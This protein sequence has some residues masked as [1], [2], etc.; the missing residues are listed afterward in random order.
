MTRT[1]RIAPGPALALLALVLGACGTPAD[2]AILAAGPQVA[3]LSATGKL[4]GDHVASWLTGRECSVITFERTGHYCPP[5]IMVDRSSQ[6]CYQTL[7]GV[8]CYS[9]ADPFHNGNTPVGSPP[10]LRVEQ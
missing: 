7:G 4:P 10:P 9:Q 2:V 8:E 5:N 6:Y 3:V 1:W